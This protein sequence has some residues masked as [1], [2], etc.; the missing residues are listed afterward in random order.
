MELI[1]TE[2]K[3]RISGEIVFG[4]QLKPGEKIQKGDV[5]DSETGSWEPFHPHMEGMILKESSNICIR[6][7]KTSNMKIEC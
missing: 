2:Y 4:I 3:H 5:Y 7:S 1:G 6:K